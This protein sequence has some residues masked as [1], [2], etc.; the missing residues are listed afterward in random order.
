MS[1]RWARRARTPAAPAGPCRCPRAA[2]ALRA[3]P[4]ALARLGLGPRRRA[5]ARRGAAGGRPACRSRGRRPAGLG[6]CASARR[7][8]RCAA[9]RRGRGG[10]PSAGGPRSPGRADSRRRP[11]RRPRP[12]AHAAPPEPLRLVG[13]GSDRRRAVARRAPARP[14][15][16][17]VAP[18]ALALGGRRAGPCR[19]PARPSA[20]RGA[21][22]GA[23]ARP[24]V[25]LPAYLRRRGIAAELL[26]DRARPTGRRRGGLAGALDR[27]RGRAERAVAAGMGRATG[28]PAARHGARRGRADR[29]RPRARTGATPA[30]PTCSP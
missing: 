21:V 10:R 4:P 12:A 3:R 14:R 18:A 7:L 23:F 16:P 24:A 26:L 8:R 15:G 17:L 25:R 30:W 6:G 29:R 22:P 11:A 9:A 13:R 27:M 19:H 5:G 20:R 28:G 1:A 2:P